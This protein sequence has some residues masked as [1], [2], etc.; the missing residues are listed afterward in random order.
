MSLQQ[1]KNSKLWAKF[2][3]F[4]S[5]L[6]AALLQTGLI[7]IFLS[8]ST[9]QNV[10]SNSSDNGLLPLEHAKN[11]LEFSKEPENEKKENT[12]IPRDKTLDVVP[13]KVSRDDTLERL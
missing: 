1:V 10:S 5:E 9:L 4:V 2:P 13:D 3:F 8:M 12:D 7:H 6:A 11:S